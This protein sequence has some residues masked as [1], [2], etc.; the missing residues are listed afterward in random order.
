MPTITTQIEIAASTA[1]VRAQ[2]LDFDN[3]SDW[4]KSFIKSISVIEGDKTNLKE[5]DKLEVVLPGM[6]INPML[7]VSHKLPLPY[8]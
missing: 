2:F 6:T 4:S 3:Y 8:S 1:E 7:L 5:G